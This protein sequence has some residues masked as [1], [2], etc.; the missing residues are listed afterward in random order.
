MD[1]ANSMQKDSNGL[2]FY[3]QQK[4]WRSTMNF[5]VLKIPQGF[6][7]NSLIKA[8]KPYRCKRN[9][10]NIIQWGYFSLTGSTKPV[11]ADRKMVLNTKQCWKKNLSE[12]AKDLHREGLSLFRTTAALNIQPWATMAGFRSKQINALKWFCGKSYTHTKQYN[13]HICRTCRHRQQKKAVKFSPHFTIAFH[14]YAF[15]G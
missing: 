14:C 10:G 4:T 5:L 6:L 1:H 13:P 3:Q 15:G 7:V 9:G 12:S 11:Q 8:M 2:R